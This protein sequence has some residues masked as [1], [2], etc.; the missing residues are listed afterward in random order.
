MDGLEFQIAAPAPAVNPAR[1]DVACFVGFVARRGDV[2]RQAGE[3]D[4]AWLARVLPDW[5]RAALV[6]AGWLAGAGARPAAELAALLDVPVPVESWNAFADLFAWD[7]R[8][9][10]GSGQLCPTYLGAAIRTFFARGGRRAYVVRLGDPWSAAAS[11]SIRRP[12]L[13]RLLPALPP[14]TPVD[15]DTWRGVGHLFGLPD[16]S[17]L[18]L[19]DLPDLFAADSI[20]RPTEPEALSEE[21][22]V[23]LPADEPAPTGFPSL[24]AS[25]PPGGDDEGFRAWAAFVGRVG[26]LL[27]QS[28]REVQLV[29]AVP[30]PLLA[31]AGLAPAARVEQWGAVS[32]LS[33]AF[34]QL[35]YPWLR[36]PDSEALP[37][38]LE[39]PDATLTGLLAHNALVRGTW[40]SAMRRPVAGLDAVEP[41]LDRAALAR[42][43]GRHLL[44]ERISIFAPTPVGFQLLADVTTYD[45]EAC[46]N[47]PVNRLT[48]AIVRAARLVGEESV[49]ENNGE[50]LWR[51]LT[52]RLNALMTGLWRA[53]VFA[54]ASPDDA[55]EVVCDRSTMTQADIDAGRTIARIAFTAAA[56]IERIVIVFALNQG[57]E[58]SLLSV[59]SGLTP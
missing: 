25:P 8:P 12:Q 52:D 59:N 47:A 14:P 46:R 49:F 32:T 53:G 51:L 4:D 22:F 39:P 6:T 10:D 44:R 7:Q 17:F 37:G 26:A 29:A 42:P 2:S 40:F 31:P 9:L 21:K 3:D 33:T 48:T 30:L 13:G 11:A 28:A 23:P 41:L 18:N 57:G 24:R 1:A 45:G 35:A 36:T 19:P 20:P 27:R 16:V 38:G 5:V 50:R 43:L 54:G 55:F 58:V 56:P 15:R 34:V